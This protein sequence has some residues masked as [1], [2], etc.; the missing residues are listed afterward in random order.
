MKYMLF[1]SEEKQ[2]FAA[3]DRCKEKEAG[4]KHAFFLLLF[5][6]IWDLLKK[7]NIF[8]AIVKHWQI[9]TSIL[10]LILLNVP[11]IIRKNIFTER[12]VKH[13]NRLSKEAVG[14]PSLEVHKR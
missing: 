7:G 13:W 2:A 10:Q 4:G 5:S 9:V 8:L 14:S 1:L 6:I 12:V 11:S 3:R